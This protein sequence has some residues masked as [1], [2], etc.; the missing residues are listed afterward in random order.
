MSLDRSRPFARV[1]GHAAAR[2]E[3]D[4]L[5]LDANGKPLVAEA[6]MH[7]ADADHAA[8]NASVA[9]PESPHA[10]PIGTKATCDARTREGG[11]CQCKKLLRGRRCK[12]HGGSSTGPRTT[13]GKARSAANLKNPRR[14]PDV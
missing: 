14:V 2:F 8:I 5:L 7:D 11:S 9:P 10:T 3:Q 13:D 6:P 12:F 4:G 1:Y